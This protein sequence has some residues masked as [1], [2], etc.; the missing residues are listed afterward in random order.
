MNNF[1]NEIKA[2]FTAVPNFVS[3]DSRTSWKAK[4]IFL[5]L[6]SRPDDWEFNMYEIQKNATDGKTSLQ[7][8][9][10]ELEETGY[11]IRKRSTNK[12]G[13]FN[14]WDWILTLPKTDK[15]EIPLSGNPSDGKTAG[16][17]NGSYKKKEST[18]TEIT[19][20]ENTN[21]QSVLIE[22]GKH[23]LVKHIEENFPRIAKMREPLT[24]EQA[25]KLL[26]DYKEKHPKLFP[27]DRPLKEAIHICLE[28]LNDHKNTTK[29]FSANRNIRTFLNNHIDW[30]LL[31]VDEGGKAKKTSD[32]MF[33]IQQ[34]NTLFMNNFGGS[35]G[36]GTVFDDVFIYHS[37]EGKDRMYKLN[38]EHKAQIRKWTVN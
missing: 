8:G 9:L 13:Q 36:T 33:T 5:Y 12:K 37:G 27:T 34:A 22:K 24:D 30:K 6:A 10:K 26:D 17:E 31:T 11:L 29:R 16:R 32:R 19:K 1:R 4:G 15:Q 35:N 3:R 28:E 7:T 25:V 2:E 20:K 23:P 21:G 38:P 14:G 18:K